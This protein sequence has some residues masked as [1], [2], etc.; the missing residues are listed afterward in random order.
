MR[1][2]RDGVRVFVAGEKAAPPPRR[3]AAA[4]GES[5]PVYLQTPANTLDLRGM[6]V[7]DALPE[8]DAFLDRLALAQATHAFLIHGHGTG[9]LKAGVRRHL[10]ASPYAGKFLPAPRE[11]GGD[12]VTIVLL[13]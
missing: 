12:G 13:G 9:A 4:G 8:I 10:R 7:D 2:P 5:A 11:Q 1:V 6:Y 3:P